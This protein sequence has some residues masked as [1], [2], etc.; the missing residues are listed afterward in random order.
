MIEEGRL[1]AKT[2]QG[3]DLVRGA[4]IDQHFM[5]RNRLTRLRGVLDRHPG[6]IG[7]GIDEGTAL[8]VKM[9]SGRLNVIGKSYVMLWAPSE[10]ASPH[11]AEF[12]KDGD[13][14]DLDELEWDNSPLEYHM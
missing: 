12:L 5:Q 14:F 13:T 4:V 9:D 8:V 7:I 10:T 2:R 1:E 3:L 6:A 11:R